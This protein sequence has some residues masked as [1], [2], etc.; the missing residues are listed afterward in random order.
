MPA[1]RS[2]QSVCCLVAK[3]H[4][5]YAP[6]YWTGRVPCT[7]RGGGGGG[8]GVPPTMLNM[9]G[10]LW[11]LNLNVFWSSRKHQNSTWGGGGGGGDMSPPISALS[12]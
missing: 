9:E 8:G 5:S 7:G 10:S 6:N 3:S 11:K 12:I 4:T 1:P 2:L